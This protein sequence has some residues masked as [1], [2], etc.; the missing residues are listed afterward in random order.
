MFAAC[1][2]PFF[3]I[4]NKGVT[5]VAF[6][7]NRLDQTSVWI[8]GSAYMASLIWIS[9]SAVML[10]IKNWRGVQTIFIV[11]FS[12]VI[13]GCIIEI[14]YLTASHFGYGGQSFR[15]SASN[16]S[17]LP[18]FLGLLIIIAGIAWVAIGAPSRRRILVSNLQQIAQQNELVQSET[19][20]GV[21]IIF[22][23]G[24][25]LTRASELVRVVDAAQK[26]GNLRLSSREAHILSQVER[27]I[28]P[29]SEFRPMVLGTAA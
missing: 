3:L 10:A 24:K 6:I 12:S 4:E 1:I 23:E 26:S 27:L 17:E 7:T 15:Y 25:L 22:S 16:V 20:G 19:R 29:G 28:V 18:F 11:G 5:D 8:Y 9:L 14:A 21:R 2:V 13:I